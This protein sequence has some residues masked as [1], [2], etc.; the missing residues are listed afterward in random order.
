[1][2]S[3]AAEQTEFEFYQKLKLKLSKL[4]KTELEKAEKFEKAAEIQQFL[5]QKNV[6]HVV[7]KTDFVMNIAVGNDTFLKRIRTCL[8]LC[9]CVIQ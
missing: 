2:E 4:K 8:Q 3:I 1:M 6:S 7:S 5:S 9:K